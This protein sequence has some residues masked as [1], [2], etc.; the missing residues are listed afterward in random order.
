MCLRP[1]AALLLF[2][3]PAFARAAEMP[4]RR[5]PLFAYL[6]GSPAPTMVTYTPSELDPRQE[7][8]QRRLKTSSI[9]AD[10]EALRPHFDGLIL[11]G[12]HEAC[13]PRVLAVAKDLKYRAVLLGIW[14]PKSAAEIDG[15]AELAR[16]FE[17]DMALGVLIGNEGITF[18]RY[19]AE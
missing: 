12:Y 8:N 2:L 1:F 5:F 4:D 11:Y 9:R 3:L 14:D 18:K 13:T 10:L 16:L 19:E 17:K 15:V 6:T 7:A